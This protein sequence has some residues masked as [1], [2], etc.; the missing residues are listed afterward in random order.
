MVGDGPLHAEVSQYLQAEGMQGLAHLPGASADVPGWLSQ[1]DF[2]ALGS[3]RE[4]IS[5][6]VLEAMA[7]GLPVV[8]SAT[9]G[10]M[11]LVLPSQTGM[12]VPPEN[13]Q[14]LADALVTYAQDPGLRGR[15]GAAAAGRARQ[16]YSLDVMV[17]RYQAFYQ[18][19][20]RTRGLTH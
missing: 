4:G 6:T 14:A 19:I 5:N 3:K 18:D 2:Y 12:L 11:E 1:M 9:G 13:P 16:E 7:S 20:C 17:D 10:N 8:A 15:H